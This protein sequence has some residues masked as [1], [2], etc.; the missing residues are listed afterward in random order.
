MVMEGNSKQE[1]IGEFSLEFDEKYFLQ[2]MLTTSMWP[3]VRF[4]CSPCP[5]L[6]YHYGLF[7]FHSHKRLFVIYNPLQA[8]LPTSVSEH[9]LS[10]SFLV[11]VEW[12]ATLILYGSIRNKEIGHQIFIG[13]PKYCELLCSVFL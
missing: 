10:L 2:F 9:T 4:F 6:L 12:I 13:G 5:A 3:H 1:I 7:P 8:L 11:R